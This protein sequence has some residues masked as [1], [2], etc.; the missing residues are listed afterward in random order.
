MGDA[1][2]SK[3]DILCIGAGYVGGPTMTVITSNAFPAQLMR[4]SI[5][6]VRR[7]ASG[8]VCSK[9]IWAVDRDIDVDG[10]PFSEDSDSSSTLSGPENR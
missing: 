10:Q 3:K 4:C 1:M 6:L 2:G 9:S 8:L 7:V 5:G